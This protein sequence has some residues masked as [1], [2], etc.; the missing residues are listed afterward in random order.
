MLVNMCSRIWGLVFRNVA[1]FY[2]L[3]TSKDTR[4]V[5]KKQHALIMGEERENLQKEVDYKIM[6]RIQP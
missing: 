3:R 2:V 1:G 6:K 5:V 4:C